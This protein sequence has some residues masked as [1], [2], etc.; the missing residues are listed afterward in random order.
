MTPDDLVARAEIGDVLDD[1]A[2]AIDTRDWPLLASL[3]A[4][5]ASLDYTASGGPSGPRDDVLDWLQSTLPGLTLT[6]HLLTNRRIRV[7]G[8]R[9]KARSELFNPLLFDNQGNTAAVL[10]G[11]V[12]E[13]RLE[14]RDGRWQIVERTHRTT[15]TAGPFPAKVPEG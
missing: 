6:Q 5:D 8:D 10:L 3:F 1:Y 9:A 13:D 2:L 14:R 4:P 15:W 7:T 12:Y 11:G